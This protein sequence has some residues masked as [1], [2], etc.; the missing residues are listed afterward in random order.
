[1]P[2][3]PVLARSGPHEL[4][5]SLV[6]R[7]AAGCEVRVPLA[8]DGDTVA[9]IDAEAERLGKRLAKAQRSAEALAAQRKQPQYVARAGEDVRERDAERARQ[10]DA[11][12]QAMEQSRETLRALREEMC[13]PE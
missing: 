3:L 1:M 8:G 7:T 10:L 5:V 12:M 2:Q 4:G 6:A 13:G 11:E 9:R